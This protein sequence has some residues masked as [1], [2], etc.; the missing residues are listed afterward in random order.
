MKIQIALFAVLG[1]VGVKAQFGPASSSASGSGASSSPGPAPTESI[2]CREVNGAWECAGPRA[3]SSGSTSAAQA[4]ASDVPT[5]TTPTSAAAGAGSSSSSGIPPPPT[6]S[7]GCVLHIDHYHCEGPAPGYTPSATTSGEPT[8]PSPT[9]SSNCFW[10]ETHWDCFD[11]QDELEA[12]ESAEDSGECIIHVGHTHGDCSAEDLACGAILMEDFNMG[13]HIGAVFIILVTSGL[14]AMIPLITGW[15]R[16]SRSASHESLDT[17]ADGSHANDH[18]AF[19][20]GA[21]LWANIFFV[22]RHFGTGVILSTA[23]IHL[24]FHGFVMF[25][26]ECI[27]HLSYES[28][29]PAIALAAAFITF[30][31]DF[32]GSR[33]AH[34]KY[35]HHALGAGGAG[36]PDSPPAAEK[37][38]P[39][40]DHSHDGHE[41]GYD[42]VFE[43][44]QN[45]EVVLL[46]LGII[47]HSIMIGVTLGAGS[48]TGWTT[49]LIVIVFHQFFEGLALGA[50]IAL[51]RTV[52]RV[53]QFLM[54][55]AFTLITPIGI[56]IGI[57]V[58]HSFSQNGKASLLSVGILNSISAGIL[59]Y[60]AFRLLSC[61]FT[62]GPLRDSKLTKILVALASMVAGMIGM[63]VLGKW[64]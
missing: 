4:S 48:G 14:G 39:T 31:F 28:T 38:P 51:L 55:M 34:K 44:R 30:L 40:H 32:V 7:V 53:K 19:G 23:F 45:W 9:E 1:A 13:L 64:A 18:T 26:N 20:K 62:D 35:E 42:L 59:L 12:A 43:G 11:S 17:L 60:A 37:I 25:Q 50:R 47:F 54:G 22:A 63:S 15:A 6:E 8:I 57:G 36:S 49:L 61:D 10:H 29:A 33:A 41:H 21:G 5:T 16:K 58:R 46:E 52:S 56:A 2:G 3:A 27:G 24:L